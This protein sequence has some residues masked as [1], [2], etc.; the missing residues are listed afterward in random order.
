[1]KRDMCCSQLRAD[2]STWSFEPADDSSGAPPALGDNAERT[3]S[4]ESIGSEDYSSSGEA[5][6]RDEDISE[7]SESEESPVPEADD[8]VDSVVE[9]L[10]DIESQEEE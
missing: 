8:V 1:M 6:S 2:D 5:S 7:D 10:S 4:F 3:F 9:K